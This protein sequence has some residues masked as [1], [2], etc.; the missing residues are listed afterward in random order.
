MR[1]PGAGAGRAAFAL[2]FLALLVACPVAMGDGGPSDRA[3]PGEETLRDFLSD[4]ESPYAPVREDAVAA[5]AATLPASREALVASFRAASGPRRAGLARVLSTDDA[6]ATLSLLLEEFERTD[7]VAVSR[8]VL[9]G[10]AARA[11]AIRARVAARPRPPGRAGQ[12]LDA[13]ADLLDRARIER[14]FLSRKSRSGAT[15]YY[16]GQFEV[17]RA[18]RDDRELSLRVCLAVLRDRPIEGRGRLPGVFPAGGYQ[19]LIEKPP[20]AYSTEYRTLA[21]NA[22]GELATADD[23]AAL[24]DLSTAYQE[25]REVIAEHERYRKSKH[26]PLPLGLSEPEEDLLDAVIATL[27]RLTPD[28]ESPDGV[29]WRDVKDLRIDVLVSRYV[30][31]GAAALHLRMREY[32][33]AIRLYQ[34]EIDQRG[35]RAIPSYNIACAYSMWARDLSADGEERAARAQREMALAALKESVDAGYSDWPWME[36]DRDLDAIRGDPRYARMLAKLKESFIPPSD[37]GPP[38]FPFP[39][40]PSMDEPAPPA[41]APGR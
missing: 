38:V 41:M 28:A 36:Q 22:V 12:R 25:L 34:A 18:S 4:L 32:R 21:A 2:P 31:D 10:L 35:S 13:L 5:L 16:R 11:D 9:Q 23:A 27:A 20:S 3:T 14:L 30:H 17:L 29:S 15:G 40:P 26:K 24:A 6:D 37:S 39:T 33:S 8:A 7:D 1:T 19:F